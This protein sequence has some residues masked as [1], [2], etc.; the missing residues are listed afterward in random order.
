MSAVLIMI[1]LMRGG[2]DSGGSGTMGGRG[3]RGRNVQEGGHDAADMFGYNNNPFLA[4]GS[5]CSELTP[6]G[7][8]K[9]SNYGKGK[10]ERKKWAAVFCSP[11]SATRKAA[12]VRGREME[13]RRRE[14]GPLVHRVMVSL[15]S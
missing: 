7:E 14:K 8:G 6:R 3:R 4:A 5:L 1:P 10:S 13:G 12:R 9:R 15:Q 11:Q 2:G